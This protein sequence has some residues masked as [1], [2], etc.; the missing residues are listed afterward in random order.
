MSERRDDT[1][2]PGERDDAPPERAPHSYYYDDG[3][4]YEVYDPSAD[5]DETDAGDAE[6]AD[7]EDTKTRGG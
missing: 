5:G 4:G 1:T 2:E 6:D 3:T 7:G